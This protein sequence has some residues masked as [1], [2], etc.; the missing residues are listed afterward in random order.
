MSSNMSFIPSF[1]PFPK[2]AEPRYHNAS[3][4]P[5][6]LGETPVK[7]QGQYIVA[8]ATSIRS[9]WYFTRP[10]GDLRGG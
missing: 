4:H 10:A 7:K 1:P 6:L 2:R 3:L 5:M 8:C 9:T